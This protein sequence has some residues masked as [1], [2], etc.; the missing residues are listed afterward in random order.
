MIRDR[1][2]QDLATAIKGRDR[3]AIAAL[4]TTL[5]AIENAEA[6]EVGPSAGLPTGGQHIA[7]ASE[8]VGS[9]DVPRHL[10]SGGE[11]AAVIRGQ[12]DERHESAAQYEQLGQNATAEELRREAAVLTRYLAEDSAP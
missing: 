12:V 2:R 6:V 1:L 4:R 11:V 8:G 3:T 10:L 9:S 5:A 7:G